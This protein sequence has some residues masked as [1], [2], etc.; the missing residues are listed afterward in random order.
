MARHKQYN[1]DIDGNLFGNIPQEDNSAEQTGPVTVLGLTF[2]DDE[3]RR[4]YFRAELR[5]KLP[6]LR[7]IEGFPIGSDDDI[8]NL[9]DPPYYTACPNPWLNDFIAEWEQEKKQLEA[10]GKRREDFV[11]REPYALPVKEKKSNSIYTAHSYHTKVPPE[12]ILK[13]LLHYT[14]P[15]DIII[16]NF[17]GTGMAGV[18]CQ[19]ATTPD[20]NTKERFNKFWQINFNSSPN[21]GVRHAILGDL[22]P[23]A[24][25]IT[26]N[27]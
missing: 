25:F 26:Y 14:Q 13:Y 10:D 23:I 17:A 19:L 15:G 22:S 21:W 24:S 8:I 3:E 20:D 2:A 6:E 7:Q 11:V 12:I 5:A 27:S 4:A 9:S 16:D 18:A 1:S